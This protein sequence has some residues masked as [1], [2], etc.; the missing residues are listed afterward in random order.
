MS[1]G[2]EDLVQE[3]KR[4]NNSLFVL[5][6]IHAVLTLNKLLLS[7]SKLNGCMSILLL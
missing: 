5:V 7:Y 6:L 4:E 2:D 3:G 1:G